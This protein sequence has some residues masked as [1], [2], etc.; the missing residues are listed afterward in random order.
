MPEANAPTEYLLNQA[1]GG[2][3][4]AFE[5][6]ISL[7]RPRLRQL[8]AIRLDNR[9][10]ARVDPSDVIQET[11]IVVA[12]RFSE[13]ARRRPLPF[14]PWLRQIA[15]DQIHRLHRRHVRTER[16]SVRRE[17][18]FDPLLSDE[19]VQQFAGLVSRGSAPDQRLLHSEVCRKVRDALD[20]L[21]ADDREVLVLRFLE[22]LSGSE[23]AA[24]L[25]ISQP[26]LRM[27]QLRALERLQSS[28]ATPFDSENQ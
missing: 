10:Q 17:A 16:R 9:L 5:K 7:N 3:R 22:H 21:S 11:L 27:R 2:D 23:A 8:V 20:R 12:R 15:L 19:S 24:I 18:A 14:Y 4:A 13:Y 25:G 26:A 28:L 6:L 1:A